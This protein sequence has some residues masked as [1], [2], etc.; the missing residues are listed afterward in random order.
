M[1]FSI[2]SNVFLEWWMAMW[3]LK[4]KWHLYKLSRGNLGL[5][6]WAYFSLKTPHW[7]LFIIKLVVRFFLFARFPSFSFLFFLAAV[8]DYS[9]V[10]SAYQWSVYCWRDPQTTLF[11]N[12][13]IKNGSHGTIYTFKNYFTTVFSVFNFQFLTKISCIHSESRCYLMFNWGRTLL[14]TNYWNHCSQI[15]G[16]Y[17]ELSSRLR[18]SIFTARLTSTLMRS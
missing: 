9:S 18:L 1:E 12:F 16:I 3:F 10:N 17:W 4:R 15:V 14:L 5:K 6:R 11:S 7:K 8:V 13:F 2:K